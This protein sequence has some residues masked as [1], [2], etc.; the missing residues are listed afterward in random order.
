MP[1]PYVLVIEQMQV[2]TAE[3]ALWWVEVF[4]HLLDLLGSSSLGRFTLKK[5]VGVADP[6][7][8]DRWLSKE[9]YK[10]R[11][12]LER[13]REFDELSRM[14][15]VEAAQRNFE[16][17]NRRFERA[18]R[19]QQRYAGMQDRLANAKIVMGEDVAAQ[20]FEGWYDW[21]A[22]ALAQLKA[23]TKSGL[24]RDR[25]DYNKRK[26]ELESWVHGKRTSQWYQKG[27]RWSVSAR[28]FV[29]I[30]AGVE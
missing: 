7:V 8:A 21:P 10:E 4:A 18:V 3:L 11:L 15:A 24:L 17:E 12:R 28:S 25:G 2:W 5:D 9:A 1:C 29:R 27:W 13:G 26:L 30:P 19:S 14:Q 23:E 20:A 16:V 22:Q 6:S